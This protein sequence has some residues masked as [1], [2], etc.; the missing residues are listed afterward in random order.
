MRRFALIGALAALLA[1]ALA[2]SAQAAFA[3]EE[4]SLSFEEKGGVAALQAGSHPFAVTSRLSFHTVPDPTFGE[5]PDGA[6]KDLDVELPTGLVGDPTAVPACSTKDFINIIP[7]TK[8]PSCS[9]SSAVG[10]IT[11]KTLDNSNAVS[12]N[13]AP[14]YNLVPPAGAVQKLGFAPYGLPNALVFTVKEGQPYNV[15]ARLRNSPQVEPIYAAKLTLWGNPANPA[16]DSLRGHCVQPSG[17][18]PTEKSSPPAGSAR[19][20]SRKPP[21]SPCRA[22]AGHSRAATSPPPGRPSRPPRAPSP[23]RR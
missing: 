5:V 14:V 18:V 8:L 16:H 23:S 21:T 4:F 12:Y 20:A 10:V 15:V 9:D 22:P 19:A 3:V 6:L 17:F 1:A 7:S 13:S 11:I 2:P